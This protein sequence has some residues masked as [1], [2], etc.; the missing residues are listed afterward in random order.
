[1]TFFH[2]ATQGKL[3]INSIE[4][5]SLLVMY[6]FRLLV[7]QNKFSEEIKPTKNWFL[8]VERLFTQDDSAMYKLCKAHGVCLF[9]FI[10]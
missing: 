7:F 1:M 2:E 9:Y 4:A 8:N 5:I 6:L 3:F 10:K